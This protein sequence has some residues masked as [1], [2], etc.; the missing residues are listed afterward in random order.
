MRDSCHLRDRILNLQ[1]FISGLIST[2]PQ[3]I[4]Q[5]LKFIEC[6]KSETPDSSVFLDVLLVL[7]KLVTVADHSQRKNNFLV[8]LKV[9]KKSALEKEIN[10]QKTIACLENFAESATDIDNGSWHLGNEVLSVC[11]NLLICHGTQDLYTD[12]GD[13]MFGM[14]TAY[15]DT[16]IQD[17]ARFLYALMTGAS[18]DKIRSV[19]EDTIYGASTVSQALSTLLPGSV[20]LLKQTEIEHLDVPVLSWRRATVAPVGEVT[21]HFRSLARLSD[22]STVDQVLVREYF[23]ELKERRV[24]LCAEY[25]L[26]LSPD[27]EFEDLFA[28]S[29]HFD[30]SQSYERIPDQ[31]LLS[32]C[33]SERK[34][35]KTEFYPKSPTPWTFPGWATFSTVDKLTYTCDLPALQLEF[36]HLMLPMPWVEQ[37]KEDEAL[38]IFTILWESITTD[39]EQNRSDVSASWSGSFSNITSN[40]LLTN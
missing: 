10:P 23:D 19:L 5:A 27:S 40:M 29:L 35:V 3:N 30:G 4:P 15:P 22:G 16:D 9:L 37:L 31:H 8:Y 13:L 28:V 12:L 17:K 26:E 34:S 18:D 24:H 21:D 36:R 38:H 11:R 7:H 2:F 25:S 32:I 1:S 33:K 39:T 20:S 6:V 14:L